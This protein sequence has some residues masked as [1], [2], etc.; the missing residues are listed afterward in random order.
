M[1]YPN[2]LF[3][4]YDKY[5]SIDDFLNENKDKLL[6]NVNIVNKKVE[7]NHLFD[8]NYHLL[9]TYGLE[10]EYVNEVNSIISDEMRKRWIHLIMVLIFVI[11]II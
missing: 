2:I 9:I 1:K 7:I 10:Q 5:N 4:R 8:C 6:C 3:F 11:I